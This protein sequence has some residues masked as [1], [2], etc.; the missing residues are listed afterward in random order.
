MIHELKVWPEFFEDLVS[1]AKPF[2]V[3]KNDRPYAVG[4]YLALNEYMVG[5]GYTGR[6]VLKKVTYKMEDERFCL[7]GYVILGVI[8]CGIREGEL[9]KVLKAA[10][11]DGC[12]ACW[13]GSCANLEDCI[14]K[15][16]RWDNGMP[17]DACSADGRP[18]RPKSGK[19]C[20]DWKEGK[21]ESSD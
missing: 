14:I 18:Y 11:I 12:V 20:P 1:G 5:L 9:T 19:K 3:R 2:E 4:D 13:C 8:P 16:D 17:C 6:C 21:A 7:P 10:P 15:D